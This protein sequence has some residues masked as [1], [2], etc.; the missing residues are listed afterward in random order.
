MTNGLDA[1]IRN[2]L[3]TPMIGIHVELKVLLDR[4]AAHFIVI[5]VISVIDK[6]TVGLN[7]RDKRV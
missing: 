7:E 5:V 6:R 3:E 1:P 4:L 2:A